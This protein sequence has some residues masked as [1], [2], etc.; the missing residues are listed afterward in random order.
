M[1]YV[2]FTTEKKMKKAYNFILKG[3]AQWLMPVI[4]ALLEAKAVAHSS[5]GVQE[6]PGKHGKTLSTKNTKIS[7]A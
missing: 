2:Y 6:Q 1:C 3:W 4:P 5:S 7:Q